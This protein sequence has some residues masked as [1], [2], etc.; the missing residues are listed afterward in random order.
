[1]GETV[2]NWEE[3]LATFDFEV[4]A[5]D[6][7][8]VIKEKSTGEYFEFHNDPEGVE[9]CINEH[10]FIYVG[11]NNKGYDNYILKGLLNRYIPAQIKIINDWIIMEKKPGWQ[12]P[13]DMPF[14][15]IPPTT[16]LMLDMPLRQS[17]KE[18]EGNMCMDIQES[19]VDFNIDHA[20]TKEEFEEMLFYCRHDVDATE[21]L[22]DERM[23]YLESKAFLGEMCGLEVEQALY[24]TNAQLSAVALGAEKV[25]RDDYRDYVIPPEVDQSL[26]PQSILDFIERFR[27]VKKDD[28]N[29]DNVKLSWVG[30]IVGTEHKIGLGGI[31]AAK[32]NYFEE[33]ND[34][35]I[36]VDFDVTLTRAYMG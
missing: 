24:K 27:S 35:R 5:F 16:D 29:E 11:Y 4:T 7:L 32:K 33:S 9:D 34:K 3:R 15:K 23:D 18:L 25:E 20:W 22:I 12:F 19:T 21:R 30:D 17:L 10:D 14:V 26:I 1:M 31:H 36:I 2:R 28:L 8:L 6:W 13:Y